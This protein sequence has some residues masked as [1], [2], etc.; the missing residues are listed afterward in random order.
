LWVCAAMILPMLGMVVLAPTAMGVFGPEYRDGG[1]T[2]SILA[3]SAVA[4]VFNNVLGQVLVSKGAIW[5]RAGL[6][7]LLAGVFVLVSWLVVPLARDQG[8]A[9]ANLVAYGVTAVAVVVPVTL[10][11]RRPVAEPDRGRA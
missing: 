4:V 10:Y 8:L 1:T 7:V 6:D 3:A 9:L 2:L 11:L 5:W